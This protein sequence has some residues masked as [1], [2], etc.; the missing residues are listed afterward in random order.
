M[1]REA[2]PSFTRSPNMT[3]ECYALPSSNREGRFFEAQARQILN[4]FR[5]LDPFDDPIVVTRLKLPIMS[6]E[7]LLGR[8]SKP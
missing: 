8:T 1:R 2:V 7:E 3:T 4:I 5:A 6:I